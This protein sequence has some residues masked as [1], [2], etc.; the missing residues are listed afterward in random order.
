MQKKQSDQQKDLMEMAQR[1]ALAPQQPVIIQG[2]G[3]SNTGM[4]VGLGVAALAAIV[5]V[6]VLMNR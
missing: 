1:N 5:V 4:F 6:V 2:G 3:G